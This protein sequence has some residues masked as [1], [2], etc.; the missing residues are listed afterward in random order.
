MVENSKG[1]VYEY[2]K[3]GQ[4]KMTK[5]WLLGHDDELLLDA[6]TADEKLEA[7]QEEKNKIEQEKI[8]QEPVI[9]RLAATPENEIVH[10]TR[11]LEKRIQERVKRFDDGEEALEQIDKLQ[12]ELDAM[13]TKFEN[14]TKPEREK[15]SYTCRVGGSNDTVRLSFHD[16]FGRLRSHSVLVGTYLGEDVK[17]KGVTQP[18]SYN[19]SIYCKPEHKSMRSNPPFI[20]I[21][22]IRNLEE[23]L[24]HFVIK[25]ETMKRSPTPSGI[26]ISLNVNSKTISVRQEDIENRGESKFFCDFMMATGEIFKRRIGEIRSKLS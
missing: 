18:E 9:A 20:Q 14:Q 2:L 17:F 13:K 4:V 8:E 3:Q 16:I 25:Y 23:F 21:L 22:G 10:A 11:Q 7:I 24:K 12:K 6:V 5:R 15:T 26:R 1:V 19:L